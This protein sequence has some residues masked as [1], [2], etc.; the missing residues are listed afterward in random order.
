MVLSETISSYYRI[1]R[2]N[3]RIIFSG[4]FIWF[5]LTGFILFCYLMFQSAYNGEIPSEK[6]IYSQLLL[7]A[8]LLVFYPASFGI[9]NDADNRIMEILFGIPNY[10]YKIWLFRLLIIYIEIFFILILYAFLARFLLYPASPVEMA[11]QLMVPVLLF[12]NLAFFYS[13]A[14]R[15]G[16]ATA[17][18]IILTSVGLLILSQSLLRDTMWSVMLNP[19]TLPENIHP[20]IWEDTLIKNRLIMVILGIVFLLLGLF[21]LQNREKFI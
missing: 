10:M 1:V 3:M 5:L 18:L 15:S 14:T 17:V 7:P 12:G 9:Q 21:N 20:A 13:T 6:M 11:V 19:F 2:Y 8:L 4:K 16:N